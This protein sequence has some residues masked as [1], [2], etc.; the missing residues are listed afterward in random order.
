M[1]YILVL[2]QKE[3]SNMGYVSPDPDKLLQHGLLEIV[4][5][6]QFAAQTIVLQSLSN[7]CC[8]GPPC[9]CESFWVSVC[10]PIHRLLSFLC[11]S[12]VH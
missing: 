8:M 10:L 2:L 7:G 11:Y 5:T 12:K 4:A 9:C 6:G 3:I 1:P